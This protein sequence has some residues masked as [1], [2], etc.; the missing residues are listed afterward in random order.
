VSQPE[1]GWEREAGRGTRS[2]PDG[3]QFVSHRGSM[4]HEGSVSVTGRADHP[5]VEPHSRRLVEHDGL[6]TLTD[7]ELEA[8]LT[9]AAYTPGRLRWERYQRLMFERLRRRPV[10]A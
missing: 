10:V 8:E 3:H 7:D 9:I 4:L 1:Q 2:S 5:H 6:E